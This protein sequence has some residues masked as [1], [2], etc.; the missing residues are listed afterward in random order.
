MPVSST[1]QR[2]THA[3]IGVVYDES[4]EQYWKLLRSLP[5]FRYL[6]FEAFTFPTMWRTLSTGGP[7]PDYSRQFDYLDYQYE[8]LGSLEANPELVG[9]LV[10]IT[11]SYYEHQT[12]Y[13]VSDI[14]HRY[15]ARPDRLII[16]TNERRFTPVGN[17]R[18]LYMEPNVE[19]I[20]R[21]QSIADGF[22]DRYDAAGFSF[23]LLDTTNLYFQD[24]AILYN[25]VASDRVTT[26]AELLRR[27]P[28][29][30]YLP[31]SR[32]LAQIFE[33]EEELGTMPL[34]PDGVKG[35]GRWLRRRVE[36][37]R[38]TAQEI[39]QTLNT[40]VQKDGSTFDR[41]HA[42]RQKNERVAAVAAD[43][44]PEQSTIHKRYH[45]WLE[46]DTI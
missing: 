7:N 27:L 18:P 8:V 45:D 31:L 21:Y 19:D 40:A 26:A 25:L 14:I 46:Q 39:A 10:V 38:G 12:Q 1:L 32:S 20:G 44:N 30:P 17:V 3:D 23:P 15:S 37:D 24:N 5:A 11:S 41:A 22:E 34:D 35:L 9:D 16:V 13:S 43:L 4:G 36:L 6:G 33:R 42:A 29:S 28:Q 2:L